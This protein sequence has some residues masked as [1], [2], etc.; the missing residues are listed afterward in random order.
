MIIIPWPLRSDIPD[1][2]ICNWLEDLIN[3]NLGESIFE[4]SSGTGYGPDELRFH[5]EED[6]LAFKLRFGL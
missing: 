2:D 1:E 5:R 4:F 3:V 6:A